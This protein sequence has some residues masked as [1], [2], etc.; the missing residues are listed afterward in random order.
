MKNQAVRK[1]RTLIVILALLAI[2]LT[3]SLLYLETYYHADE[4]ALSVFASPP[5]GVSIEHIDGTGY[6]FAPEHPEA[7]LV[8]Y[9]GGK[10]EAEAYAPLMASCAEEDILCVL[11]EVPFR[12]AVF[13]MNAAEGVR[14]LFPEV[15]D[16]YLA[17]H[18]LGGVMAASYLAKHEEAFDGIIF[19]ASYSTV[20]FR[21]SDL[22]FLSVVGSEDQV[23]GWKKY[24]EAKANLPA[25][26]TEVT[27][28]GGCHAYFGS[29]GPQK[30]DGTPGISPEEQVNQTTD[31]ITNLIKGGKP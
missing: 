23:L 28:V 20:D 21:D 1:K 9:P 3:A 8:F 18:S 16:W 4:A 14:E 27:I 25:T 19:L 5:E 31:A 6:V 17:G 29:Y 2:V 15:S 11:L 10:V 13:D 24:E 30:G 22:G 26:A 7:G 12:L